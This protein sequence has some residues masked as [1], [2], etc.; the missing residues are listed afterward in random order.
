MTSEDFLNPE[1]I[2]A[3]FADL[4]YYIASAEKKLDAGLYVELNDLA[5]MI[6]DISKRV[7][8]MPKPLD[9]E[10]MQSLDELSLSLNHLKG[11][12]Q[13]AKERLSG[14]VKNL[15]KRQKAL[16]LYRSGPT[17]DSGKVT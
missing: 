3:C 10:F 9:E 13:A 15:N 5:P 7:L 6:E 8:A 14:E 16:K 12:M 2:R 4:E 17:D 11:G 1:A